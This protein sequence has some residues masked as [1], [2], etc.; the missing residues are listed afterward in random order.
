MELNG[1][2]IKA[3]QLSEAER[4]E[5]KECIYILDHVRI[6]DS[7][8]QE[9]LFV[10]FNKYIS[11]QPADRTCPECVREVKLFWKRQINQIW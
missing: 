11:R 4:N 8:T 9:K 3:Q 7:A 5:I 6:S 1:L 2:D 10:L